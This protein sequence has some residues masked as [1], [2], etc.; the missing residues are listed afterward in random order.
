MTYNTHMENKPPLSPDAQAVMDA[1]MSTPTRCNYEYDLGVA[2]EAAL[3][4]VVPEYREHYPETLDERY[5]SVSAFEVR[6]RFLSI[7]EQLKSYG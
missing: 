7:V 1:A 3:N 5:R 6:N 4:K 2:I